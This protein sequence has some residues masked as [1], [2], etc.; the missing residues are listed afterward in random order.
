MSK[1]DEAISQLDASMGKKETG[2][3]AFNL[4]L[5]YS[6]KGD[7]AKMEEYLEKAANLGSS[8][9]NVSK[10]INGAKA[11][12]AI[13]AAG[14]RDDGKYKEA[15]DLLGDAPAN[16]PNMFNK[17]L[18][19]LLQGVNYDAAIAS[20]V[21]ATQKN[22]DDAISQ[23]GLAIAYARKGDENN[24]AS[25]LKK[26]CELDGDLKAKAA[27]DVEFDKFSASQSF[28]DAIK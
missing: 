7:E 20:M 1:V 2:E 19:Q 18:A 17:G 25:A 15:E 24:M 12:L 4:A 6:M 26:A 5:A 21:S 28:K 8:D 11:Y 3:A 14:A 9:A 23:Y 10:L 27:K 22:P 13:K 16:N